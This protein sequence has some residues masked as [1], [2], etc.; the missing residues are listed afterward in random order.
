M[1]EK[2]VLCLIDYKVNF[3]DPELIQLLEELKNT[4][5]KAYRETGKP[6]EEVWVV[7]QHI[8]R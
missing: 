8:V 4:V 7:A 3:D 2:V 1:R 6:E 5:R